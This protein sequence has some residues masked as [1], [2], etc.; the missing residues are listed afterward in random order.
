M[1]TFTSIVA[2]LMILLLLVSVFGVI[3]KLLFPKSWLFRRRG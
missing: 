2:N 1:E 3:G